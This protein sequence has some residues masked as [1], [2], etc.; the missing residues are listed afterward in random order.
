MP[1]KKSYDRL[2][3]LLGSEA[4]TSYTFFKRRES[5]P[6]RTS[7]KL[8]YKSNEK[9]V[10]DSAKIQKKS[11]RAGDMYLSG[12]SWRTRG[13][14]SRSGQTN[15]KTSNIRDSSKRML[16]Q[17]KRTPREKSNPKKIENTGLGALVT[18]VHLHE[19]KQPMLPVSNGRVYRSPKE[20]SRKPKKV[21]K[22]KASPIIEKKVNSAA[23]SNNLKFNGIFYMQELE[24]AFKTYSSSEKYGLYR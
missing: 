9:K 18:Q 1:A 22:T 21:K 13:V 3:R 4:G 20:D 15:P 7:N 24:L 19:D 6:L 2:N 5:A 10:K 16:S 11:D 12:S 23:L 17:K 14:A 8:S